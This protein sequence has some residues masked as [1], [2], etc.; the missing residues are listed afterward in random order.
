MVELS[1]E[2]SYSPP[3]S[4][5]KRFLSLAVACRRPCSRNST[6]TFG[7]PNLTTVSKK[8]VCRPK[9]PGDRALVVKKMRQTPPAFI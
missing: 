5:M 2:S 4:E 1:G 8:S 9:S 7:K 6:P 3:E